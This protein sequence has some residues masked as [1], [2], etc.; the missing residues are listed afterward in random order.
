MPTLQ[1][2][3]RASAVKAADAVPFRLL[4]HV[5]DLSAGD[6]AA[7]NLL[8]QGDNLD[9]LKALLPFYAGRVKCI[10]IDPPYNTGSAFQQYDD[11]VEHS[12]WL[13]MMYPR[14]EL[15]RQ[16]LREDG[17]IWVC[18]DDN[19]GHYLKVILDEVFGRRNFMANL[20]WQKRYARDSNAAIG[21]AHDHILVYS[22]APDVFRATRNRLVLDAK[23]SSVYKNPNNDPKGPWQSISFTGAGFRPN[24]MYCIIGPNGQNHYPPEGRHWAMLEPE[25]NRLKA[26]GRLW[27]GQ[28]GNGVPRVIRYLT[29]VEGLVASS[30]WPHEEVGHNDEGKK[31][32]HSL[33]GK[34]DAF[35]TPKPERLLHRIV[36]IATNPGDIVLD[37]F[38]GSATTAAVAHKMGRR[39]IGIEMGDHAVTH[40]V[41][42]L[43]KVVEGEQGGISEQVGWKGGGGFRFLRLGPP[44]LDDN[45]VIHP[46]IRFP[47]LAAH[48]WFAATR[49]GWTGT[50]D[51][52]LLGV[53]GGTAYYLLFNGILGDRRPQAG[54]VLN[55]ATARLLPPHDGPKV[56]FGEWSQWGAARLRAERIEF[57]MIPYDISVR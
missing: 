16:F 41:P 36:H 57:R 33:F 24:Q 7:G 37:S 51:S 10:A 38:L 31:E 49:T 43:R 55:A 19:E 44:V 26:E 14:L 30:W 9:A 15:L 47:Q 32:I 17:S 56:V 27:F 13:S 5:P 35:D 2:L 4:E 45:R 34:A 22:A 48:I 11:N 29:E 42:R 12:T 3:D 28:N 8:V 53:H 6:P 23:T 1:W 21:S 39:Y 18:I 50:A 20:V 40:C 54:N 52:P 25:Y 46:D